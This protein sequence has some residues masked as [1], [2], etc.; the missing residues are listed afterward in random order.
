MEFIDDSKKMNFYITK[1]HLKDYFRADYFPEYLKYMTLTKFSKG[2][3]IYRQKENIQYIYFFVEGKIRVSSVLSN[4]KRQSLY[5]YTNFGILGDLELFN[6]ANPHTTIQAANDS[7]CIA[8]SLAYTKHLLYDDPVFLRQ[9]AELLAQKLCN[10]SSNSSLN[11]YYS[12]VSRLCSYIYSS[13]EK[14]LENN[15]EVLVFREGLSETA[16]LL[17]TSYRHLH[18]TLKS[19]KEMGILEKTKNGYKVINVSELIR[20]S[21]DQYL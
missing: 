9:M 4:G 17:G 6:R 15:N 20:L 7:Y 21:S 3:Y 13:A 1:F 2:E 16:E 10:S 19:L 5:F 18:R 14:V 11:I 8:L 12:L